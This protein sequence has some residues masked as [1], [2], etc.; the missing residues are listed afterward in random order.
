MVGDKAPIAAIADEY[1]KADPVYVEKTMVSVAAE[2]R[3]TAKCT[4]TNIPCLK[5]LPQTYAQYRPIKG[6]GN[7]GWRGTCQCWGLREIWFTNLFI[8]VSFAYLPR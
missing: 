5:A 1:A 6:D 3:P 8:A 7:C 4:I 2:P